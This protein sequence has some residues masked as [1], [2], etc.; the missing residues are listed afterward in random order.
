[1]KSLIIPCRLPLKKGEWVKAMIAGIK[2]SKDEYELY[3]D[4]KPNYDMYLM[5]G[6][7]R[8][9]Y[10]KSK[11]DQQ[12]IIERGYLG[13][14]IKENFMV[15]LNGLNGLADFKNDNVPDDRWQQWKPQMREWKTGG[16]YALIIGQVPADAALHGLPLHNWLVKTYEKTKTR[17]D[18]VYFRPH[19][20]DPRPPNLP[21]CPYDD[22]DEAIERASVV[23]TYTSNVG[24]L[25]AMMG[26]PVIS[27]HAGSMVYN[28]SSHSI[29]EPLITPDREDWGRKISYAQWNIDEMAQ[30]LPWIHLTKQLPPPETL[31]GQITSATWEK[32]QGVENLLRE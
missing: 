23:I 28:I 31:A 26:T 25:A 21:L 1:M 27:H 15:G 2:K 29:D 20:S 17:Y 16:E 4:Y 3:H 32:A 14:R 5:W 6:I 10:A 19:P 7:K 30:G 13:D 22:L 8:R 12:M 18:N 9:W 11:N 24:V